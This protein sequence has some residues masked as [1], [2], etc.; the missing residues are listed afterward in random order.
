VERAT[1]VSS[2]MAELLANGQDY[3]ITYRIIRPTGEVRWVK[4]AA[5]IL[6][7]SATLPN[8]A[9]GAIIDITEEVSAT[10]ALTESER[11]FKALAETLPQIIL[12]FDGAGHVEYLNK[13]WYEFTGT[14]Q[15]EECQRSWQ[16][17]IHPDDLA[18]SVEAWD[19]SIK[20]GDSYEMQFRYR[21]KLGEYRWLHATASPLLNEEGHI[22]RWFCSQTDIHEAKALELEKELI[23]REFDHRVKNILALV[24]GLISLS[25][26]DEPGAADFAQRLQQR[27]MALSAAH[28]LVRSEKS[29]PLQTSLGSLLTTLLKAYENYSHPRIV[30]EGGDIPITPSAVTP[31]ALIFHELGTNSV[32][33]GALQHKED[34]LSIDII[35]NNDQ[36]HL[37]WIE[38]GISIADGAPPPSHNGFG[39][40]LLGMLVERQMCGSFSRQTSS[41]GL[42]IDLKL[43]LDL[44]ER[45]A[46]H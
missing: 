36:A 15:S 42:R 27:L 44:F 14:E 21:Y 45:A 10:N 33:Y 24:H 38:T 13:R 8:R 11:R 18:K 5:C 35:L 34:R 23:A 2:T 22:T 4:S 39:S 29:P 46:S 12:S 19:R 43:P 20:T 37:I 26:R 7:G 31:L 28:G 9:V 32:K 30:I 40:K 25:V 1:E 6:Q 3:H 17:F 41:E 16:D